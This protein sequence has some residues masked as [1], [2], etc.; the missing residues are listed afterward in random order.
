MEEGPHACVFE[1]GGGK[2]LESPATHAG[3]GFVRLPWLNV[4]M[5]GQRY[6]KEDIA[7]VFVC[8]A[9]M[10]QPDHSSWVVWDNNWEAETKKLG[11]Y[12]GRAG[13]SIYSSFHRTTPELYQ[14]LIQEG[15]IIKADTLEELVGK[16]GVPS[17][18][19]IATVKRYNEL[20]ELGQDLDYGKNPAW[21]LAIETPP[22]YAARTGAALLV[23][24]GGLK[25]NTRLQVLDTN[26]NVIPGLYAAGNVSGGFFSND[27]PCNIPGLTH[28]RAFT[29][30]RLAGLNASAEKV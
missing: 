1:D 6:F 5:L 24:L 30:G 25:I 16:M 4:N 19:F 23:T 14:K 9:N 20:A 13:K 15:A 27:Y 29:F 8:N 22:F 3:V 10:N 11:V 2:H 21:M 12:E 26:L 17:A 28:G 18:A 7:F